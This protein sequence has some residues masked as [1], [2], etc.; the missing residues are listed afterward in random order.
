MADK[1]LKNSNGNIAEQEVITTSAGA[2]DTGKIAG[3]DATGRFDAS[4]MPVGVVPDVKL[5]TASENLAAGDYVNIWD[6]GGITKVRKA[7]ATSVG[8]RAHGYVL[9]VALLGNQASVYFEG[10]N[11]QVSG[12]TGGGLQFLSAANPG[13]TTSTPPSD[14][15][16]YIVQKIGIS[17][18]A[19]EI[20]TEISSPIVLA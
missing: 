3:L 7:D 10:L 9:A 5:L 2:G 19:T 4:M 8:K 17:L 1:F 11:N 18:S 12:L 16:G 15:T 14:T 6:D 20:A 13:L